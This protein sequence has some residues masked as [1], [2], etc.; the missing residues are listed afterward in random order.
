VIGGATLV[1]AAFF[2]LV[3][4]AG[5]RAQRR[6]VTTGPSAMI[7]QRGVMIEGAAPNDACA[8]RA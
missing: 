6:R 3:V 5:I 7:G 2:L 4:G 1:T 8:S